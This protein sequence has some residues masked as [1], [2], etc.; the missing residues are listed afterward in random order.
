MPKKVLV[1]NTN[2]VQVADF[3]FRNEINSWKFIQTWHGWIGQMICVHLHFCDLGIDIPSI[4]S[5]SWTKYAKKCLILVTAL[6]EFCHVKHFG[7]HPRILIHVA[8]SQRTD[9]LCVARTAI[10]T[11]ILTIA[12]TISLQQ[13]WCLIL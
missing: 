9:A 3:D 11:L 13:T 8:A 7:H 10:N 1:M 6:I 2:M 12:Y 5:E 4:F